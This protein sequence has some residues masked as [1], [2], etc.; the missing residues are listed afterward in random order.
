MDDFDA[1]SAALSRESARR[2]RA[3]K[4]GRLLAALKAER[5]SLRDRRRRLWEVWNREN[6]EARAIVRDSLVTL[7][8]RV[9]G[10]WEKHID[11]ERREAAEALTKLAN[12]VRGLEAVKRKISLLD[13][14]GMALADAEAKY[15]AAFR[16]KEEYLK[17]NR[18]LVAER[19]M[20]LNGKLAAC[21]DRIRELDEARVAGELVLE[22]LDATRAKLKTARNWGIWDII[23]GGFISSMVKYERIADA[24]ESVA[25]VDERMRVFRAELGDAG[26]AFE[27]VRLEVSVFWC[28]ADILFDGLISDLTV[29]DK[30]EKACERADKV[31]TKIRRIVARLKSARREEEKALETVR[32]D[33][34]ALVEET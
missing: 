10:T 3:Q 11:K 6:A 17:R 14:E 34:R 2:G 26:V 12:C 28:L 1:L 25:R 19:L 4:I 18:P 23:D 22:A 7:L 21:A 31:N 30:I 32:E 20:A 27:D 8:Y 15:E 33:S 13:A 16:A 9:L 5:D 29:Q 24:N